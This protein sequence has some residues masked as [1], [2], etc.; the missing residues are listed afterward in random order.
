MR[1]NLIRVLSVMSACV[2][3]VCCFGFCVSAESGYTLSTEKITDFMTPFSDTSNPVEIVTFDNSVV[4]YINQPC[5]KYEDENYIANGAVMYF[6]PEISSAQMGYTYKL[7][8][9]LRFMNYGSD[10]FLPD[11]FTI[12]FLNSSSDSIDVLG[13][14]VVLESEDLTVGDRTYRDFYL[15]TYITG[16]VLQK[17]NLLNLSIWSSSQQNMKTYFGLPKGKK[18]IL[19]PGSPESDAII[20][21]QNE[22]AQAIQENQDKNTDKILNGDEDLD[23]SDKTGAVDG[24]V[25]DM[26]NATDEALG[27]KSDDEINEEISGALDSDKIDIDMTKAARVSGFFDKL[28]T[29]FG[30]S[31]QSLLLLSLSLGLGAF[32]I[33]RRYG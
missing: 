17:T 10:Y 32:L 28:L 3:A 31:Y 20:D 15:E 23:V 4:N 19:R 24:S 16:E 12:T 14:A 30:A 1:K 8:L 33:G 27:G 22:N 2:V 11:N 13:K 5:F 25:G 9:P 26:E 21:N 29:S 18:I 6:N 7:I